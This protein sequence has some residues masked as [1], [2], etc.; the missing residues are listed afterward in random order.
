[1]SNSVEYDEQVVQAAIQGISEA[2]QDYEKWSNG[3][4]LWRAPEYY[5]T[6]CIAQKISKLGQFG[7]LTLE[8][9][10]LD[11][12]E[13]ANARGRGRLPER[14]RPNGRFDILLWKNNGENDAT[15]LAPIE[16]KTKTWRFTNVVDDLDR[17]VASITRNNN[18]NNT[19]EF[20]L[21][22]FYS[23]CKGSRTVSAED[24]LKATLESIENES[25][26]RVGNECV[27]EIRHGGVRVDGDDAWTSA[28]LLIRACP[29]QPQ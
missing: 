12:V 3:E 6:T 22:A 27:V 10:V 7:Y 26:K 23:S 4:W 5:A 20:G 29:V 8:H 24:R 19:I 28:V 1:M 11:A 16:V 2:H 18:N 17:I 13:C 14:L 25:R 15:P 9:C 21:I